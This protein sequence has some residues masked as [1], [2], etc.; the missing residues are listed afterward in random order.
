MDITGEVEDKYYDVV[1]DYIR[2]LAHENMEICR[3]SRTKTLKKEGVEFALQ[4]FNVKLD[5]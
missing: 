3:Y 5:L 4:I 2:L 1:V